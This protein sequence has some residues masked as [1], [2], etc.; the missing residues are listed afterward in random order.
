MSRRWRFYVYILASDSGTI[1]VGFTNDLI[2]RV[3]EHRGNEDDSSFT[4]RYKVHKLVYW[5]TYRYVYKAIARE[6]Q[7]K[8]WR[9]EKKLALID[10]HN[11]QWL[12]QY[13]AAVL[14]VLDDLGVGDYRPH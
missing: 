5:E 7:L 4:N 14:A 1:Y 9:R 13:E 8:G 2:G 10:K 11:P 6:K 3:N 12:D